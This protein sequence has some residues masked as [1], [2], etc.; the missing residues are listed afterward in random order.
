MLGKCCIGALLFTAIFCGMA[1]ETEKTAL[2]PA[3]M[4]E[5]NLKFLQQFSSAIAEAEYYFLPD[6]KGRRNDFSV[7]YWCPNCKRMH[8]TDAT[9]YIKDERPFTASVFAV[10]EDEFIAPDSGILPGYLK[11]LQ[12]RFNGRT[13]LADIVAF[14]PERRSIKIRTREKVAGVSPLVF[15]S[16]AA[17]R[18][19]EFFKINEDGI[20]ISGVRAYS[21]GEVF[22][23]LNSRKDYLKLPANVLLVNE[24]GEVAAL[25]MTDA[26][27]LDDDVF[28]PPEKWKMI[29]ADEYLAVFSN[30]AKKLEQQIFPARVMLEPLRRKKNMFD[31]SV[32]EEVNEFNGLAILLRDGQLLLNIALNPTESARIKR[33]Y[34]LKDGKEVPLSFV[35]SLPHF[36]GIAVRAGQ[37][38]PGRGIELFDRELSELSLSPVLTAELNNFDQVFDCKVMPGYIAGLETSWRGAKVP[39]FQDRVNALFL[40]DGRLLALRLKRRQVKERYRDSDG[41]LLPSVQLRGELAAFDRLNAPS[42]ESK[43]AWLGLEGQTLSKELA[44]VKNVSRFTADGEKAW[45]I[46]YIYPGSPAEN[47]GLRTGDI[48]LAIL[49]NDSPVELD[50][51]RHEYLEDFP[52]QHYDRMPEQYFESI[53]SPWPPTQ[54][55]INRVL[56]QIGVGRTVKLQVVSGGELKVLAMEIAAEPESFLSTKRYTSTEL[57]LTL[58]NITYEVAKYL[59]FKADAPGIVIAAV[60]PGGKAAIAGIKP[61]EIIVSVNGQSVK[62]KDEFQKLI[63]GQKEVSLGVRRL[64]ASRIVTISLEGGGPPKT[65]DQA[66]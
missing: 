59:Q 7:G 17:G 10:A 11:E 4:R 46:N 61:Y 31:R 33:M 60:R 53:P 26:L 64:A 52:W 47:L 65:P 38:L 49:Y 58:C 62:S 9:R 48:L 32:E 37:P 14:C 43:Q 44:K 24:A 13:Y 12:I 50:D 34:L 40:P 18:K 55:G 8:S 3:A 66:Q 28:L 1:A 5:L 36:G 16:N 25:S 51:N 54:G 63:E 39:E 21:S 15:A 22:R 42:K 2:S 35:G 23:C 57:G 20:G 45:V 29:A 6:E 56:S 19:F 41:L 30:F 27:P